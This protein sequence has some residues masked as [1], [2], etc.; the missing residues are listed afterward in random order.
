MVDDK[1]KTT[2]LDASVGADAGQP[3]QMNDTNITENTDECN[4]EMISTDEMLKK[5]R[6]ATDPL[7]L[8]SFSYN[9][10]LSEVLPCRK[11]VIDGFL[12]VGAYILAG[13]PKIGKSF[14][15][16]QIAYHVS[17]GQPI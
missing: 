11:S 6:R 17:I 15:V 13:A 3:S 9:E 1:K 5:L 10:L 2:V 8:R 12:G 14:L 4:E 16:A 7:L